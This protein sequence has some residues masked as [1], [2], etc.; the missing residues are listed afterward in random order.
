MFRFVDEAE[1]WLHCDIKACDSRKYNCDTVCPADDGEERKRRELDEIIT[2][3]SARSVSETENHGKAYSPNILTVGPMRSKERFTA[4]TLEGEI[5]DTATVIG[6]CV[7]GGVIIIGI[8]VG[9]WYAL[10]KYKAQDTTNKLTQPQNND[11]QL[12][13]APGEPP[14][15]VKKNPLQEW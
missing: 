9:I 3:R 7:V 10:T 6:I 14:G 11:W 2:S 1:V 12:Y 15:Q 4:E 5:D 13:S 8:A